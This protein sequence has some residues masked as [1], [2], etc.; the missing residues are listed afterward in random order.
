MIKFLIPCNVFVFHYAAESHSYV[1]ENNF[2]FRL[3]DFLLFALGKLF[4]SI[5]ETLQAL[6]I[7]ALKVGDG[8]G[9]GLIFIL[10]CS[11]WPKL[12][13]S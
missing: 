11:Q 6:S 1:Q 10:I 3:L 2:R 8:E 13:A 12:S 9:Y 4:S 5:G 7:K